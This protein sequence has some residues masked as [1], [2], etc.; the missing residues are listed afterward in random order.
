MPNAN[1]NSNPKCQMP[2]AN[3]NSDPDAVAILIGVVF[4]FCNAQ[5]HGSELLQKKRRQNDANQMRGWIEEAEQYLSSQNAT[6]VKARV[7]IRIGR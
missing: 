7:R 1:A 2:N 3:A 4:W 5:G 6:L